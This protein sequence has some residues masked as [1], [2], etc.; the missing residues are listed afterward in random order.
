M[1]ISGMG[2]RNRKRDKTPGGREGGSEGGKGRSGLKG[3]KVGDK[4]YN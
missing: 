2:R 4:K 1:V 3:G